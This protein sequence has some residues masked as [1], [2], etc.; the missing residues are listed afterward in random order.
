[1]RTAASA[2]TA[3]VPADG[4]SLAH[5]GG[6]RVALA[7]ADGLTVTWRNLIGYVRIPEAMFFSSIQPIMFVLLFRYVFGGAIHIPGFDYVDFLLP[8][9]FVQTVM[10][11]AIGTS[12]GLA[13]D[14]QKGLI[15]RFRSLPMAHS[16]VLAG[17][18]TADLVRNVFVV[19][20]MTAVGYLVGFNVHTNVLLFLAGFALLL[21]F[22]YALCWGFT[23]VGLTA[24]NSET[25]QLMSFPILFPFT[26]ASSAFV[27]VETMPGWLQAFA[28]NQPVT[29]LVDATRA[30]MLGGPTTEPVVKALLW[31]AGLLLVLVPLAVR[32]YRKVA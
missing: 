19:L 30:L 21:A 8:G 5:T 24:P 2:A 4:T 27:R 12:I 26:F 31:T 9:I 32:R 18:T 28:R 7:V 25:A 13:E 22:G 20:L 23:I 17:R 16:A 6:N 15:E 29:A 10:F 11:G 3:T 1:M 14:L